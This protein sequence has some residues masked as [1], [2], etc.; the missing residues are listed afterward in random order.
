[1]SKA[2][3]FSQFIQSNQFIFIFLVVYFLINL[4]FLTDFPYVHS[5]ESWLS[6]LSRHILETGSFKVTEPFF[7]A[8][9]RY[10]HAIR[11]LFHLIQ[12]FF[13]PILGYHI[14]TFRLISLLFSIAGLYIFYKLCLLILDYK[15]FSILCLL[16]LSLDVQFIY[17][18]HFARQEITILFFLLLSLYWLL[19]RI[20]GHRYRDDLIIGS[21]I[22][23]SIGFHP[24]S[25]IIA[26]TIGGLYLFY[27]TKNK[28]TMKNLLLLIL[29]IAAFALIFVGLSIYMDPL[30]LSHYVQHGQNFG[31]GD[32]VFNKLSDF[33]NFYC[34][35][36]NRISIEYYMPNV[37]F[38]LIVFSAIFVISLIYGFKTAF[39]DTRLDLMLITIISINLGLLLIGRFNVTSIIFIFPFMYLLTI[40]C[41]A[42]NFGQY[43]KWLSGFLI[44][45]TILISAIQIK[46]YNQSYQNYLEQISQNIQNSDRVLGNL[47]S[48]YAFSDGQL[49]DVR[50]LQYLQAQGISFTDYIRTNKIDTILYY[51]ELAFMVENEPD[52]NVMYGDLTPVFDEMITFLEN[53]CQETAQFASPTYGTEVWPLIDQRSWTIHVFKVKT[54]W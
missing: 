52:Y 54:D 50:N 30:Y 8:Y 3:R 21:V 12:A 15:R 46:P 19:K 35:V 10:P 45:I 11:I 33:L 1:M 40:D 51:E 43:K 4:F 23:L 38:Q 25:F 9:A 22:G 7:D 32:S 16:L 31:V 36:F 34:N 18:S 6:G 44:L 28:L 47:N 2:K 42:R 13:I 29:T 41:L 17:A 14:F 37:R 20:D 26:F 39:K 5:D 24:N 48:E 49:L 53:N 27:I